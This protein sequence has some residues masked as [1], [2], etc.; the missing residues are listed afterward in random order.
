VIR[1]LYA[2][3]YRMMTASGEVSLS[4]DG[5]LTG[6]GV[7]DCF[8]RLYG[9]DLIDTRSALRA[10]DDGVMRWSSPLHHASAASSSLRHH[11]SAATSPRERSETLLPGWL[12]MMVPA[13]PDGAVGASVD[14]EQ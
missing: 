1:T 10:R 13:M 8:E 11:G 14:Q 2:A 4:L 3:G 12:D 7:R 5:Y 9:P 6:M